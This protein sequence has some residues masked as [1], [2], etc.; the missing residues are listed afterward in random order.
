[1]SMM[2]GI[3]SVDVAPFTGSILVHHRTAVKRIVEHGQSQGLFIMEEE[4]TAKVTTLHDSVAAGFGALNG[5]IKAATGS[6]IDLPGLAFLALVG[7]GIY[8][9]ARG[10]FAA[11]AWY[12]A[13]WYA[14]GIFGRSGKGDD[15]SNNGQM[16]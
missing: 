8:Q 3:E 11:P 4:K 13:F 15:K 2:E 9:I 12:T 16:T 7:A 5:R 10:N 14:L 1:M 6:G